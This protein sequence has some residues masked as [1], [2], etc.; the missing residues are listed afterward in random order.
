MA[1]HSALGH[2]SASTAKKPIDLLFTENNTNNV[3]LFGASQRVGS[4]SRTGSTTTWSTALA[5][6]NPE[7]IGTK[8]A[9]H[10]VR[11]VA[12]G[13]SWTIRLR[14]SRADLAAAVCGV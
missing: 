1:Q 13:S 6:V 2:V 5:T 11:E 3:R 7:K 9:A 12:A 4:S 8:A 10:Y 14:L